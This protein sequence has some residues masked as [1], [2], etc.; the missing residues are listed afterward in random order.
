MRDR[1]SFV[2]TQAQSVLK[3]KDIIPAPVFWSPYHA[4]QTSSEN[5][6]SLMQVIFTEAQTQYPKSAFIFWAHGIDA[7][8]YIAT[9]DNDA[10]DEVD[11]LLRNANKCAPDFA[12]KFFIFTS[13]EAEDETKRKAAHLGMRASTN[14]ATFVEFSSLEKSAKKYHQEALLSLRKVWAYMDNPDQAFT[15][16][17]MQL[18]DFHSK[19]AT[20]A[21]SYAQLIARFPH[22]RQLLRLYA[23]F[24][25]VLQ[26]DAFQAK[27]LL[28]R[29]DE[30]ERMEQ[31]GSDDGGD[32]EQDNDSDAVI[33]QPE[34]GSV[35]IS[36]VESMSEAGGDWP[37]GGEQP[38]HSVLKQTKFRDN[39][40]TDVSPPAFTGTR[41]ESQSQTSSGGGGGK[42]MRKQKY[43]HEQF[44][45]RMKAPIRALSKQMI[46]IIIAAITLSVVSYDDMYTA[47]TLV[48]VDPVT[49]DC[50]W[51]VVSSSIYNLLL[52]CL[53][54][55]DGITNWDFPTLKSVYGTDPRFN[56]DFAFFLKNA[57]DLGHTFNT[58]VASGFSDFL[59]SIGKIEESLWTL[60]GIQ[61]ALQIGLALFVY[62]RAMRQNAMRRLALLKLIAGIPKSVRKAI[63]RSLD[64]V[65]QA[66]FQSQQSMDS[67]IIDAAEVEEDSKADESEKGAEVNELPA[68]DVREN[69]A[70]TS[71][72]STTKALFWLGSLLVAGSCLV[73]FAPSVIGIAY[74]RSFGTFQE[75]AAEQRYLFVSKDFLNYSKHG[76]NANG[77]GEVAARD[78]Q[79]WEQGDAE[80][81]LSY[82][83]DTLRDKHRIVRVGTDRIPGTDQVRELDAL[84]LT[85]GTCLLSSG[86]DKLVYNSTIKFTKNLVYNGLEGITRAFLD[87]SA[88]FLAAPP[89]QR[90]IN[91]D[92]WRLAYALS[93]FMSSG[94][95]VES[96]T[97]YGLVTAFLQSTSTITTF[98][99]A[100]AVVIIASVGAFV[101]RRIVVELFEQADELVDIALS[102][103]RNLLPATSPMLRCIESG[104]LALEM[105][106]V[107]G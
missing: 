25:R 57:V 65:K 30:L 68:R 99:F 13:L 52:R 16:L 36:A 6:R 71:K 31:L 45:N 72:I 76:F 102:V 10:I 34:T 54:A 66:H 69:E 5:S 78:T 38:S 17:E 51:S 53:D 15:T 90:T 63:L 84:L 70:N 2:Q 19:L 47:I 26:G 11:T 4:E 32:D 64:E 92:N 35:N 55:L 48:K 83:I 44:K 43:L 95:L 93:T 21:K 27:V 103:P 37:I 100:I 67:L 74:L 104:G 77:A 98:V 8:F 86:C 75:N 79:F 20:A 9:F 12:L 24:V 89:S 56:K 41:P 49:G 42:E 50:T 105:D 107:R 46:I 62:F 80:M 101:F 94:L 28:D 61:A 87:A 22:T 106:D 33:P 91:N 3:E 59:K 58:A 96:D 39:G 1:L 73:I 82:S 29:A 18:S 85:G 14:I 40:I 7:M 88:D 97:I 23:E 60:F 81:T